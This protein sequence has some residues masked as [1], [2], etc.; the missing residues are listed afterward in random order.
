MGSHSAELSTHHSSILLRKQSG[1]NP[2]RNRFLVGFAHRG[3]S[4]IPVTYK[5]ADAI[6]AADERFS[7]RVEPP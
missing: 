7:C 2:G 1:V 5:N 6:L 4:S 3:L